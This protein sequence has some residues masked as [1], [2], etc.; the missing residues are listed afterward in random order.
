MTC[1]RLDNLCAGYGQRQVLHDFTAQIG[2]GE[3]VLL[4]GANASGKTTLV[5][6]LAG[7]K[8]ADAGTV[9]YQA[10]SRENGTPHIGL[11]VTP[12]A[13]PTGLTGFHA[14]DLVKAALRTKATEAAL[15]YAHLVGLFPRLPHSISSYSTGTKQKLAITLAL[16]GDSPLL[17]LD[18][19]LNGLDLPSVARTLD[20][21]N[22]RIQAGGQSVLLVTH[23]IDLVQLYARR[24]WL[25][26]QGRLVREWTADELAQMQRDGA[27]I[28]RQILEYFGGAREPG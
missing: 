8:R 27:L 19:S 21:L 17:L 1:A 11:A 18:E 25:L 2:T 16:I 4:I 20:Y 6:V 12:E 10:A 23:N 9:S 24:V 13:L 7:L 26:D 3:L 22:T 5:R 15:A 14:M 28:S